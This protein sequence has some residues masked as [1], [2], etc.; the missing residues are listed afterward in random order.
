MARH[1]CGYTHI[2]VQKM[3]TN[4]SLLC[5]VMD[6][7]KSICINTFISIKSFYKLYYILN[8]LIP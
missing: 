7:F 2:I 5:S 8:L 1:S 3:S 6:M 4:R